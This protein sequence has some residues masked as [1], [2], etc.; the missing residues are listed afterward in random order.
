MEVE[1]CARDIFETIYSKVSDFAKIY[2]NGEISRVDVS[3]HLKGGD[4]IGMEVICG[5]NPRINVDTQ[6]KGANS[7]LRCIKESRA[8]EK[9]V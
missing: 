4:C 5:K 8:W 7:M 2:G 1:V 3:A 6:L 9:E